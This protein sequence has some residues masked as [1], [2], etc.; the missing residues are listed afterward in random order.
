MSPLPREALLQ[1]STP[2]FSLGIFAGSEPGIGI[3]IESKYRRIY[4]QGTFID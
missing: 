2:L 1:I 4:K 3:Y